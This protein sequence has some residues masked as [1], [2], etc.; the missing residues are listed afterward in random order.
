[1]TVF[2]DASFG[3]LAERFCSAKAK[4]RRGEPMAL[5]SYFANNWASLFVEQHLESPKESLAKVEGRYACPFVSGGSRLPEAFDAQKFRQEFEKA[6]SITDALGGGTAI[7]ADVQKYEIWIVVR[8]WCLRAESRAASGLV[9]W[10]RVLTW[11]DVD[12]LVAVF[13]P[14]TMGIDIGYRDRSTEVAEYCASTG[15]LALKGD[16]KVGTRLHQDMDLHSDRDLF[17]GRK[18]AAG[19]AVAK[20]DELVWNSDVFRTRLLSCL[21]GE[22]NYIWRTYT[23][24]EREYVKQVT[25]TEKRNGVW[26]AFNYRLDHLFDDEV[27]QLVLARHAGWIV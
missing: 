9:Y 22:S 4:T 6:L 12:K 17:E 1:M 7:T 5:R 18:A 11:E 8:W 26:E 15:A 21:R 19:A 24:P 14:Q 23:M 13:E 27:Q 10:N 16:D 2:A 25:S 3:H 20:Y